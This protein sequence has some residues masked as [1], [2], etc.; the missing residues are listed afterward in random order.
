MTEYLTSVIAL[1]SMLADRRNLAECL[2]RAPPIAKQVSYGVTRN[3][4]SLSIILDELLNKPITKKNEDLKLLLLCGLYSI[5]HL[6]RPAYASVNAAVETASSL[7]KAWAKGLV[8]GVLRRYIRNQDKITARISDLG[9]K[10][11]LNHPK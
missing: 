11:Q 10:A 3:Y 1:K 8:N 4:F 6:N 5:E 7:H 9:P 2:S